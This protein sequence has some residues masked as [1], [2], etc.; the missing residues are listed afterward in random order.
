V[1]GASGLEAD[2][3][4]RPAQPGCAGAEPHFFCPAPKAFSSSGLTVILQLGKAARR[5]ATPVVVY[6]LWSLVVYALW[7]WFAA[8]ITMSWSYTSP[9]TAMLPNA[10]PGIV[11]SM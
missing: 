3:A 8:G 11:G 10:V 5:A 2:Q 4:R 1:G 7:K 6:V 9:A